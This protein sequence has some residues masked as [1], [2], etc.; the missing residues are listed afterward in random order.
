MEQSS[1][2]PTPSS[3]V[4]N[5]SATNS[6]H[7][8][9]LT[10]KALIIWLI[11]LIGPLLYMSDTDT[12]IVFNSKQALYTQ[13]AAFVVSIIL[14]IS[15]ILACLSGLVGV[16]YIVIAVLM[17]MKMQKKEMYKLPIIGDMVK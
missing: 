13:I 16:A 1:V 9:D 8:Q 5:Q 11:P 14:G 17:I 15:V 4:T 6:L 12:Y 3:P 2:N 10:V 7:S